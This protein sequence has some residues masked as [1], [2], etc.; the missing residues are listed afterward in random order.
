MTTTVKDDDSFY[1]NGRYV[2]FQA[3]D[4]RFRV[5][6]HTLIRESQF[7]ADMFSLP[8]LA[9][10]E[11]TEGASDIKP[12][13]LPESVSAESFRSLLKILYP[14]ALFVDKFRSDIN[15]S[16]WVSILEL[17][18]M[19][20]FLEC[21]KMAISRLN[22]FLNPVEKI[23]H[24]R[25]HKVTFWLQQG[26]KDLV[27][28]YATITNEEALAL[29]TDPGSYNIC[30]AVSLLRIREKRALKASGRLGRLPADF[31]EKE[32]QQEF[33][34]EFR[35]IKEMEEA[36]G[37]VVTQAIID[38]FNPITDPAYYF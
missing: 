25:K 33:E 14:G 20:Y 26:Y 29:I 8:V 12:I 31:T 23:Y 36:Y 10:S 32:I 3:G 37:V 16:E 28:R 30:T 35:T 2:V 18:S 21:R 9:S 24:G 7:F 6:S 19:W 15:K 11:R 34:Q 17:A 1:L 13:M 22:N 38:R 27:D 5:P 4:T